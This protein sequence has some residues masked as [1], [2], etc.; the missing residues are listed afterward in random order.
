MSRYN[1]PYLQTPSR[2]LKKSSLNLDHVPHL[3]MS[4][5]LHSTRRWKAYLRRRQNAE[6]VKAQ[7]RRKRPKKASPQRRMPRG[8]TFVSL[9][10]PSTF[11]L[12]K[13]PE[14]VVALLREF[15]MYTRK[16]HISLDL[17]QVTTLT[18]DA[19]AT[20][21]AGIQKADAY[22][23]GNQPDDPT[24]REILLHSGFFHHVRSMQPL[25]PA[26]TGLIRRRESKKVEPRIAQELIHF[27]TGA[28]CGTSE[29][30]P[31][32]YR[33]LIESMN[34][35]HNHAAKESAPKETWWATVSIDKRRHRICYTFLDTGVGIF[36]SVRISPLRRVYRALGM[37]SDARI[38]R[39]I[40][41]GRV[42]SST[43]IPHRGK[44]L[45]SIY[46]LLQNGRIESLVIVAN[47]VYADVG[48]G[49]YKMLSTEFP[50]TLLYWET[51]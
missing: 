12:V 18:A 39:D 25:P 29:R 34:N 21:I 46:R 28:V 14:E 20:L 16:H 48:K 30:R 37:T 27:G 8:R 15:E 43:R 45:P 6:M 51:V 36:R 31:A 49:E 22:V 23:R 33:T 41:E 38:L 26:S 35:T 5:K 47:G 10:V 42:E 17:S 3:G 24:C 50:G 13:N 9:P 2:Q 44:G 7:G 40:L 32:S 19:I 1:N 11:S 4:K